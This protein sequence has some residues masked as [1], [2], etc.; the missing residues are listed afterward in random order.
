MYGGKADEDCK[1]RSARHGKQPGPGVE[2]GAGVTTRSPSRCNAASSK[3]GSPSAMRSRRPPKNSHSTLITGKAKPQLTTLAIRLTWPM[4]LPIS[5]TVAFAPMKGS[6]ALMTRRYASAATTM[7]LKRSSTEVLESS[8][9]SMLR[10][11]S[12][13]TTR[14]FVGRSLT[15]ADARDRQSLPRR[16]C[17]QRLMLAA[18]LADRPSKHRR[19]GNQDI[20]AS[21]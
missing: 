18:Y 9:D 11:R 4:N 1:A 15:D 2:T 19:T 12:Q 10:S 21:L 5:F 3:S 7:A 13:A 17:P 16:S 14:P 8:V 20:G 6:E